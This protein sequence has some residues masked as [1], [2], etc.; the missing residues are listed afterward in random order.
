MLNVTPDHL[1]RHYSFKN[2]TVAK[3]RVFENQT[4]DDFAVLNADDPT[5]VAMGKNVKS[6]VY[7]FSRQREVERGALRARQRGRLARW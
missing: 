2:Y 3:A 4:E 5:C 6:R 7:W 1:D